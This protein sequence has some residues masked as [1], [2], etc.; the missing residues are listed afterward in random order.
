MSELSPSLFRRHDES[1]DEAFYAEPRL[2][3]H[4]DDA[5]VAAV[6]GLYRELF[7]PNGAVLDLMTSWVSHLPPEVAYRRVAGLGMNAAELAAN[8]RL[9]ERVV[10]NLNADPRLPFGDGEFD[11][12][13]C[14]VSVQYLTRPATVF[15]EVARVLRPGA[16]FAV[17]F[18]NR[19][20]PTKAVSAWQALDDRG[21]AALVRRYFADAGGWGEAKAEE[22]TARGRGD[23]L[24]AVVGVRA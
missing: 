9:T 3:T 5:A 16:P 6:T 14:C 23:P 20:F 12:A 18:S 1:P 8:P 10:R 24:Y 4:I 7:P 2:V 15:A 22:R 13:G 11:G 19:C 21:H 17:T